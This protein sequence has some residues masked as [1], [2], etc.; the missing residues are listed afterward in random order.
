MRTTASWQMAI[1]A[2]LLVSLYVNLEYWPTFL[3]DRQ[4]AGFPHGLEFIIGPGVFAP[5]GLV[6]ALLVTWLTVRQQPG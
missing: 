5:I 6:I 4:Y 2:W 1:Q 3:P